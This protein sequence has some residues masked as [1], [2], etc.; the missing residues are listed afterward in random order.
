MGRILVAVPHAD[1]LAFHCGGTI[2]SMVAEGHDVYQVV[3][4]NGAKSSFYQ[5]RGA[6][7]VTIREEARRSAEILGLKDIFLW[8]SGDSILNENDT[9]VIQERLTALARYLDIETIFGFDPWSPRDSHPDQLIVGKA[10]CWT[11]YFSAFPLHYPHQ[12]DFGLKPCRITDQYY[13]AYYPEGDHLET[14]DIT[15]SIDEKVEAVLAFESQMVWCADI[16]INR[17][18][19]KGEPYGHID[20]DN[21]GPAIAEDVRREA[22]E[23]GEPHGFKY[24]EVVRHIGGGEVLT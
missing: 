11:A 19:R 2:A 4:T 9:A 6:M 3:V 1:E 14:L 8:D 23:R 18:K 15:D 7:E 12:M 13:F 10:T 22:A 16:E 5:E 21:Y 24:A 17:L 20:R